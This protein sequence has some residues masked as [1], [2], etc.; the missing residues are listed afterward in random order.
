MV[1][2]VECPEGDGDL[3]Q[4]DEVYESVLRNEEEDE[5]EPVVGDS[6]PETGTPKKPK[7]AKRESQVALEGDGGV[8][9]EPEPESEPDE[10]DRQEQTWDP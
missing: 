4:D 9:L 1:K 7:I 3:S 5:L 6:P 8:P 10:E 2:T